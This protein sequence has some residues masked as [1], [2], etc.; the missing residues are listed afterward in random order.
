MI[1]ETALAGLWLA[2]ALSLLQLGAGVLALLPGTGRGTA[3]SAGEGSGAPEPAP[4]PPPSA[5]V[6]LPLP[7]G[8]LK[9][10]AGRVGRASRWD[11]V[12]ISL[13]P[14]S[15]KTKCKST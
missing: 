9:G 2:A 7:G 14:G 1:A 5:A 8:G 13:V 6:P 11:R 10:G 12:K 3:R 15:L 4:P